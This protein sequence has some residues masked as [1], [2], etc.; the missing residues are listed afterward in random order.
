MFISVCVKRHMCSWGAWVW[1]QR[2]RACGQVPGQT[3]E[4]V[5]G[6]RAEEV[7]G[8]SLSPHS[9]F[10]CDRREFRVWQC[11]STAQAEKLSGLPPGQEVRSKATWPLEAQKGPEYLPANSAE[12]PNLNSIKW[13][14]S[15]PSVQKHL[16]S[17]FSLW[18]PDSDPNSNNL[19]LHQC[20]I[21]RQLCLFHSKPHS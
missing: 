19:P 1:V 15:P 10:N 18:L 11:H 6:G 2:A 17:V 4:G 12:Q 7:V 5:S 8:I 14:G 13:N 16:C 9:C 21:C 20:L 3:L